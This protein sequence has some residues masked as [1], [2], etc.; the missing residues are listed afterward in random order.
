MRSVAA[1]V[2]VGT[3]S[4]S[5]APQENGMSHFIEHM[6]FKGTI[7]RSAE[8]IARE[9]DSLGG[10]LDAFTGRELVGFNVK[11]LDEHLPAAL[12]VLADMLQH[13]RF[14]P[15][16]IEK[17]KSVIL[18]ELKMETDNPESLV[19][20]L[21]VSHF[22]RRHPLGQP[23]LGTRKT[24]R[25]FTAERL[26]S[27]H[28]RFYSAANLTITAAG[29]LQH[30]SFVELAERLFGGIAHAG[31]VPRTEP[32]KPEAPLLLKSKRS[33][34]QVQ[35]CLGTPMVPA[36]HPMRF[37]AYTLNVI[38]GGGM[39]SRLFQNIRERQGLAYAIFS[40]LQAYQDAGSFLISA[41]TSPEKLDALLDSALTELRRMKEEL[42][43]GEEL[44][45][46]KEYMKGSLLL[47][48]E[49]TSARMGNLARQWMTFG[50]F[51][52]L[53]EIA[54]SIEAVTAEEVR[55]VARQFFQP[56][57]LGLTLLGRLEGIQ[58]SRDRLAC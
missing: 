44:R 42:V 1:G 55:A 35:L 58:A 11:V 2:W 22:W 32:P 26:R 10:H 43:S 33:L 25:A 41:G 36:A 15:D 23:I 51:F 30:E 13:P 12:D 54:E 19:H 7:R 24:I 4:R 29:R 16:E 28:T 56:D 39:S 31:A 18:E 52:S 6:L 5:E 9:M 17:E 49:S 38:L 27:Y 34:Q 45:R 8:D 21:F 40:E 14:D 48:L 3:G 53:D 20:E 50:R 47:S 46:A 37:A 57:L